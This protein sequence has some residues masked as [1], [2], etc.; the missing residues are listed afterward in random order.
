MIDQDFMSFGTLVW[1][2]STMPQFFPCPQCDSIHITFGSLTKHHLQEDTQEHRKFIKEYLPAL[3]FIRLTCIFCHRQFPTKT[4]VTSHYKTC[5]YARM[6]TP[7]E[8]RLSG[9]VAWNTNVWL[10]PRFKSSMLKYLS[11]RP[12]PILPN[13]GGEYTTSRKSQPKLPKRKVSKQTF[14]KSDKKTQ[15]SRKVL[16]KQIVAVPIQK[17]IRILPK[18]TPIQTPPKSDRVA[19][20]QE[21]RRVRKQAQAQKT[22]I[23]TPPRVPCPEC[24]ADYKNHRDLKTHFSVKHP[25]VLSQ[26]LNNYYPIIRTLADCSHADLVDPT[27]RPMAKNLSTDYLK[28]LQ[29]YYFKRLSK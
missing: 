26:F 8:Q 21:T 28:K 5:K 14:P 18:Q 29:R 4:R 12:P 2:Q 22:I 9:V 27:T 13:R 11:W 1:T 17:I 25:R 19:K 10:T 20:L 3:S 15:D 23:Q 7:D 6:Q 24:N 16:S